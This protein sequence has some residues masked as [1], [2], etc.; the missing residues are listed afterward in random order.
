MPTSFVVADPSEPSVF[1][2][3]LDRRAKKLIDMIDP[4]QH[5][6]ESR[7]SGGVAKLAREF[8]DGKI[9]LPEPALPQLARGVAKS[10]VEDA[11]F[12]VV[13]MPD[14]DDEAPGM[15][16]ARM[17]GSAVG[18]MLPFGAALKGARALSL[19]RKGIAATGGLYG[20]A[21][22]EAR[23]VAADEE[24]SN[25]A[26]IL[27]TGL[28]SLFFGIAGPAETAAK[29]GNLVAREPL[30]ISA[31]Y[32]N[33]PKVW[34]R[35]DPNAFP[36]H[37]RELVRNFNA[38]HKHITPGEIDASE[39]TKVAQA[40]RRGEKVPED[41]V[42][43]P[44]DTPNLAR[45]LKGARLDKDEAARITPFVAPTRGIEPFKLGRFGAVEPATGR[46]AATE[47]SVGSESIADAQKYMESQLSPSIAETAAAKQTTT[48]ASE[49]T[50][51]ELINRAAMLS[52]RR[53]AAHEAGTGDVGRTIVTPSGDVMSEA[54]AVARRGKPKT[55]KPF[56]ATLG[57]GTRRK[58]LGASKGG[59]EY[60][61][62]E[63]N[64]RIAKV[65]YVKLVPTEGGARAAGGPL[66][67]ELGN[68]VIPATINDGDIMILELDVAPGW[69][70]AILMNM[71]T[72]F[73]ARFAMPS[74][75]GLQGLSFRT[76]GRR[77]EGAEDV[78]QFENLIRKRG[79]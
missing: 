14:V 32:R 72:Q 53:Q 51:E 63:T 78:I 56:E 37:E 9:E 41:Y 46:T 2:S 62:K 4:G 19:G 10:L 69:S 45:L 28:G 74:K 77:V 44:I 59:I 47:A 58:E 71:R 43:A 11:T 8:N 36:E 20:L 30:G 26:R 18:Y 21:E 65:T 48:R 57:L 33:L 7:V 66:T 17:F 27:H 38:L 22:N 79:R 60:F 55:A 68:R 31:R 73:G 64:E 1:R 13:D 15:R 52:R 29:M 5:D 39:L 12:G 40:V 23:A 76:G 54:Q 42:V 70:E 75:Q 35:A 24:T 34:R 3:G 50:Q 16:I 61:D 6:L 49:A 67:S 25:T